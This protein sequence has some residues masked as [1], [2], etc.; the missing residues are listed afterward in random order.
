MERYALLF[1]PHIPY[2]SGNYYEAIEYL[3]KLKPK[4]KHVYLCGDYVDFYA[5]SPWKNDE[6][7][8]PFER[9]VERVE[10]ELQRLKQ[11]FPKANMMWIEGNHE[12]RLFWYVRKHAPELLFHNNIKDIFG[13]KKKKIKYVSNIDRICNGLRP[14]SIGKLFVL[15]GHEKKVSYGAINL[16][17]LLYNKCR[18]NVIAGHHHRAD[19]KLHKKLDGTY[20][21]AWAVGTLGFTSEPYQPINDWVNGFAFVDVFDDDDF[22]VHN[23]IFMNGKIVNAG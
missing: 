21:A 3:S 14:I 9:E 22:E 10:F 4:P 6:K 12:Q 1:D 8:L 23:K 19:Y 2:Q 15:H 18:V 16:A 7:R 5:I 17:G 13:L 20:E 11:I